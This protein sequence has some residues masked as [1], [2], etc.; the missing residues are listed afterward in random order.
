VPRVLGPGPSAVSI[1]IPLNLVLVGLPITAQVFDTQSGYTRPVI[2]VV[3]PPME[4]QELVP[5]PL[6]PAGN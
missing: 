6:V 4:V 1:R 3:Q 5:S 2:D